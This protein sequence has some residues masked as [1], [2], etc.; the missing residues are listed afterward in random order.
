MATVRGNGGPLPTGV[1]PKNKPA[2]G[3]G[4]PSP[5]DLAPKASQKSR[6]AVR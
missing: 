6:A 5:R 1:R 3:F 4:L 2:H